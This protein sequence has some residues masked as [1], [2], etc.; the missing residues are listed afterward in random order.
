MGFGHVAD[1]G[2]GGDVPIHRVDG[3]EGHDLGAIRADCG[4]L[5]VQILGVV[6]FPDDLVG[7][8]VADTL[9]HRGMVERI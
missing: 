6:V 9:Y 1:L 3:F 2:D 5:A 4:E 7:A 8:T